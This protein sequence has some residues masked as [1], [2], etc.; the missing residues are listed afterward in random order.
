MRS[1]FLTIRMNTDAKKLKLITDLDPKIDL[2]ARRAA[3]EAMDEK[4]EAIARHLHEHP[5][6]DGVVIG[7][8]A[9]FRQ[10]VNNLASNACK[11]TSEGVGPDGK[12]VPDGP[13]D[14]M[15]ALSASRLAQHNINHGAR[16]RSDPPPTVLVR[17]EVSDTGCGIEASELARG[18]LFSAFNQT[19]QGRQQGGK[20]TG[21]GL[22]LEHC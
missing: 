17:I 11:F 18:K 21:L 7:D 16:D 3:Y 15:T 20:G 19:E 5:G 2:V 9:R 13:K 12:P 22:A 10:I 14:A 8:E 4:E 6:V 1:L